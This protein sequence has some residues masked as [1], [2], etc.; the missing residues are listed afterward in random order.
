MSGFEIR[1]GMK[2]SYGAGWE[3][4]GSEVFVDQDALIEVL[5]GGV[6]IGYQLVDSSSSDNGFRDA[7]FER[8]TNLNTELEVLSSVET[9]IWTY[10]DETTETEV[11]RYDAEGNLTGSTYEARD[12]S[13]SSYSQVSDVIDGVAVVVSSGSSE[14]AS[15]YAYAYRYVYDENWDLVSAWEQTGNLR[16]NYDEN[17]N[18][19]SEEVVE[20][21]QTEYVEVRDKLDQLTGYQ[22]VATSEVAQGENEVL[23]TT[24]VTQYNVDKQIT[25][26]TETELLENSNVYWSEVRNTYDASRELLSMRSEDSDGW[27]EEIEWLRSDSGAYTESGFRTQ[28]NGVFEWSYSYSDAGSF[29]RGEETYQGVT[30][31]YGADWIFER[32]IADTDSLDPVLDEAGEVSGYQTVVS[33]KTADGIG[34]YESEFTQTSDFDSNGRYL[35]S[36]EVWSYSDVYGGSQA[37]FSEY[38]S[39]DDLMYGH[40]VGDS[41]DGLGSLMV[42]GDQIVSGNQIRFEMSADTDTFGMSFSQRASG[43]TELDAGYR[44]VGHAVNYVD[45]STNALATQS[46]FIPTEFVSSLLRGG[47]WDVR[48]GTITETTSTF[49]LGENDSYAAELS[50]A[51]ILAEFDLDEFATVSRDQQSGDIAISDDA[52]DGLGQ[53]V[54]KLGGPVTLLDGAVNTSSS[55]I[56]DVT[57]FE[58]IEERE[59]Q[60]ATLDGLQ[61]AYS[62]LTAALDAATAESQG[63]TVDDLE[64]QSYL[65]IV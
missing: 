1:D 25:G 49:A 36:T 17:W 39:S 48:P 41:S 13:S 47:E 52:D 30:T 51:Q 35:G 15:G 29:L 32:K 56:N 53:F 5:E 3:Y 40:T 20:D 31:F 22:T 62:S 42:Q 9:W 37:G 26:F 44:V 2:Y 65:S 34:T 33:E 28:E 18:V 38:D 12:G 64:T 16:V 63:L 11:Q 55:R 58:V 4:L 45:A 10:T 50:V 6:L 59:V 43:S 27:I 7:S 60:V 46:E 57:L 21:D 24:R 8:V 14:D 19:V 54:M 23:T 61:I